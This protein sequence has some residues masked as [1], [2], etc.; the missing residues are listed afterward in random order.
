MP[1]HIVSSIWISVLY[2]AQVFR[3]S[4]A[5]QALNAARTRK[6]GQ[7]QTD[8]PPWVSIDF[9]SSTYN[10][11]GPNKWSFCFSLWKKYRV[12]N[13]LNRTLGN[14]HILT[15]N[16]SLSSHCKVRATL[17]F[18]PNEIWKNVFWNCRSVYCFCYWVVS[19]MASHTLQPSGTSKRNGNGWNWMGHI[20]FCPMLMMLM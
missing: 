6:V 1:F 5:S 14:T 10:T 20:K 13:T 17:D 16:C 11:P 15:R 8:G 2:C 9:E 19:H 18:I 4:A 3:L 7:K 12:N